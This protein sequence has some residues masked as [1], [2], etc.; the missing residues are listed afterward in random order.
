MILCVACNQP[1]AGPTYQ[2]LGRMHCQACYRRQ[3]TGLSTFTIQDKSFTCEECEGAYATTANWT[4][5]RLCMLCEEQIRRE[6][7]EP[8]L[9]A[10]LTPEER[11][12]LRQSLGMSPIDPQLDL[13]KPFCQSCINH[14]ADREGYPC[15]R[16]DACGWA[17]RTTTNANLPRVGDTFTINVTTNTTNTSAV[18]QDAIRR[19][20]GLKY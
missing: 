12:Y 10:D 1:I 17:R 13:D 18:V 11:N 14:G 16:E 4:N 19:A 20:Y 2:V 7:G 9:D 3:I 6:L 5:E 8:A 15:L